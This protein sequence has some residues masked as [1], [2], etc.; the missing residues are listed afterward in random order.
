[1]DKRIAKLSKKAAEIMGDGSDY[2]IIAHKN[3]Q[4]GGSAYGNVDNIAQAFFALLH[5]QDGDLAKAVFRIIK[6]NAMNIVSNPSPYAVDLSNALAN[7]IPDNDE[8]V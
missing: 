7:V 8:Q 2:I 5:Q 3:G 1:M 4:C 6:L